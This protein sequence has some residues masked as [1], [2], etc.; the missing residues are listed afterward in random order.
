MGIKELAIELDSLL[1]E[2]AEINKDLALAKSAG[3]L[4]IALHL[5]ESLCHYD[6]WI[7]DKRDEIAQLEEIVEERVSGAMDELRALQLAQQPG[8]RLP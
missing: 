3:R 7:K 5:R 2:R 8:L 4:T 1:T 6:R